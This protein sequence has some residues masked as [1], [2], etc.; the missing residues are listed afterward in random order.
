MS[1]WGIRALECDHGLDTMDYLASHYLSHQH[2]Q[3]CLE[4]MAI[5]LSEHGLLCSCSQKDNICSDISALVLA[6]LLYE[7]H[8]YGYPCYDSETN[9]ATWQSISQ[10]NASPVALSSLLE[11]LNGIYSDVCIQNAQRQI[12]HQWLNSAYWQSWVEHLKCLKTNLQ[13]L[14]E[15]R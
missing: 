11:H 14:L 8:N 4:D 3:V 2:Q 13:T 9:Y 5:L 7:W 12:V 10:F 6:E 1:I 15:Q